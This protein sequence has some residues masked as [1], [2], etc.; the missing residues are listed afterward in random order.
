MKEDNDSLDQL[1]RNLVAREVNR[2]I[3]DLKQFIQPAPQPQP[4]FYTAQE[5]ADLLQVSHTTIYRLIQSKKIKTV[6]IGKAIRISNDQLQSFIKK[7]A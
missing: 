4:K 5:A 7:S 2:Q 6:L 1:I 3:N